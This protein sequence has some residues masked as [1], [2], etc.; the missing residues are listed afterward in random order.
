MVWC[1]KPGPQ[2]F[3]TAKPE[4][5]KGEDEKKEERKKGFKNPQILFFF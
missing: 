2:N 5:G 3:L 1:A 4:T